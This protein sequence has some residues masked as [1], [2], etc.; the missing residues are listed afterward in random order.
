MKIEVEKI[1][2]YIPKENRDNCSSEK[3]NHQ[4]V[5]TQLVNIFKKLDGRKYGDLRALLHKRLLFWDYDMLTRRKYRKVVREND[6][7]GI[8]SLPC[9]CSKRHA[10][11]RHLLN[12]SI[13]GSGQMVSVKDRRIF[14]NYF[15]TLG[16]GDNINMK[17]NSCLTGVN[18]NNTMQSKLSNNKNKE[19]D[20]FFLILMQIMSLVQID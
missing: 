12:S 3:V 16:E 7:A 20:F 1:D 5:S 15:S 2:S 10:L 4:S 17:T 6:T 13:N 19:Q 9:N 18:E 11:L 8:L 14:Q